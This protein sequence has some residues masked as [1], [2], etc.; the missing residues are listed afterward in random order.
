MISNQRN[1]GAFN[2]PSGAKRK[3]KRKGGGGRAPFPMGQHGREILAQTE[4]GDLGVGQ[5]A[6]GLLPRI[7]ESYAQP[8][9]TSGLPKAPWEQAADIKGLQQQYADELYGEY[10]RQAQPEFDK[11]LAEFQTTM[12]QTGNPPGSPQYNQQLRELTAR[13]EAAK[14]N[15]RAQSVM[16]GAQYGGQWQDMGTQNFQ[17][18][19]GF[20]L[21]QRNMPA[22]E[23]ASLM[24]M[25]SGLGQD[26]LDASQAKWLQEDQQAQDRWMMQNQPRGGGGGGE[27][28]IWAQYGFSSPQEYDEYKRNQAREDQQFMWANDPRYRQPSSASP[29][30]SAAGQFGGALLGGYGQSFGKTAGEKGWSTALKGIFA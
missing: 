15:V 5:T 30:A 7:Q 4:T 23:Y 2:N 28:P 27:S 16:G 12:N 29:W 17:N 26:Y 19:Y 9:D 20:A 18:A 25:R 8:F 6:L 13:Q 22:G 21:D 11:E 24:G 1:G 3:R 10:I 14:Q